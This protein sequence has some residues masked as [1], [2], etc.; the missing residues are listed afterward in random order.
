MRAKGYFDILERKVRGVFQVPMV[1]S[2]LLFDMHLT[3]S[4]SFTYKEPV[5]YDGPHDDII[6]FGLNVRK[7]GKCFRFAMYLKKTMIHGC[8]NKKKLKNF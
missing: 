3:V 6:S 1:H 7:A 8:S 4:D 5:G 2:V